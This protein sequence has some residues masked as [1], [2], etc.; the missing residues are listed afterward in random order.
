VSIIGIGD[1]AEEIVRSST[2]DVLRD[3]IPEENPLLDEYG[4][5]FS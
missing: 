1:I 4:A 3:H 2:L 5:L